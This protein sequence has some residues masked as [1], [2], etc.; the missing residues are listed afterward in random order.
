MELASCPQ[1]KKPAT[2]RF[3]SFRKV[4]EVKCDFCPTF[5]WADTEEQAVAKWNSASATKIF[6][7]G[8]LCE[9][10]TIEKFSVIVPNSPALPPKP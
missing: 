9:V 1:T 10:S 7:N 6:H 3:N 8:R 2:A 5:V 4:W